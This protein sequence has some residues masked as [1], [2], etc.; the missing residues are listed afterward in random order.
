MKDSIHKDHIG[1]YVQ[2]ENNFYELL[3]D[4]K[5]NTRIGSA[6]LETHISQDEKGAIKGYAY[7]GKVIFGDNTMIETEEGQDIIIPEWTS[8]IRYE[9]YPQQIEKKEKKKELR[10]W[11]LSQIKI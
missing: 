11:V 4:L 8:I 1:A 5:R 9:L 3:T 7:I 2:V 6:K 10:P